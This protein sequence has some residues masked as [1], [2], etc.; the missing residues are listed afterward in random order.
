MQ[1]G[2]AGQDRTGQDRTASAVPGGTG[3]GH[4]RRVRVSQ[5]RGQRPGGMRVALSWCSPSISVHFVVVVLH[6]R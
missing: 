3:A 1:S 2:L 6:K 5:G 4:E